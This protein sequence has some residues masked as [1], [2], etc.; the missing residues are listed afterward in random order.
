MYAQ[1]GVRL[2]T[3]SS[4]ALIWLLYG[5]C[6]WYVSSVSASM[7]MDGGGWLVGSMVVSVLG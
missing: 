4:T 5:H 7:S 2:D 1:D 6:I 3:G